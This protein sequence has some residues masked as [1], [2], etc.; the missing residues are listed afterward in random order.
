MSAIPIPEPG[1]KRER[2]ILEG[3]V[4][5]PVNPPKGCRFHPRCPMA[6]DE[7]K[8][9][10]PEFKEKSPDHWVACLRVE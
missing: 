1:L 7:C 9:M 10:E 4:P 3:D 2:I 6:I 5:S 8:V